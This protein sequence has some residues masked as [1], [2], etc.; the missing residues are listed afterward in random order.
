LGLIFIAPDTSPRGEGVPDDPQAAYD[1]GLGAGF[2]V[3]AMQAPFD[4]HYRMRDYIENELPAIIAAHFPADMQ[5]QAIM[6]HS[7]GGYV[8]AHLDKTF[9]DKTKALAFF[10][11][12][13]DSDSELKKQDRLRAIEAAEKHKALYATNLIDGLFHSADKHRLAINEQLEKIEGM[14]AE[15]IVQSL[16]AMRERE[17]PIV[18]LQ[19]AKFPIHY[20]AGA[21]DT[22]LSLE[23]MKTEWSVLPQAK[24]TIIPEIGHMGHIENISAAKSFLEEVISPFAL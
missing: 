22:V 7:M 1:F 3:D 20:F 23:K 19:T 18:F 5:R 17:S 11:S 24:I 9:P 16:R 21:N 12:T 4:Q 10:H 15:S 14:S 8:A 6:G 13:A 2:Y